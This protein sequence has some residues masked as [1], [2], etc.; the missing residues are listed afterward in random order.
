MDNFTPPIP[1]H[2]SY[3]PPF[4]FLTPPHW[5]LPLYPSHSSP[6]LSPPPF[7]P[8]QGKRGKKKA[9][10]PNLNGLNWAAEEERVLRLL[11]C[12]TDLELCQLW[13]PPSVAIM[14]SYSKCVCTDTTSRLHP[15]Q[16]A[17]LHHHALTCCHLCNAYTQCGR[18]IYSLLTYMYMYV[19]QG[20]Y[21]EA[22]DWSTVL[23]VCVCTIEYSECAAGETFAWKHFLKWRHFCP[24]VYITD[25]GLPLNA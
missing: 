10:S 8:H 5:L 11:S 9:A 20:V 16:P 19:C 22:V 24:K 15:P 21:I 18:E 17:Y 3:S 14:D 23:Y 6:P 1:S 4:P 7:M 25:I 13:D 2:P 12:V